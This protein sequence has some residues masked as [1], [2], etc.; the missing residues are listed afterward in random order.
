[1]A[2]NSD[3]VQY[4]ADPCAG[5]GEETEKKMFGSVIDEYLELFNAKCI[6]E[7]PDIALI[8]LLSSFCAPYYGGALKI[9]EESDDDERKVLIAD[10]KKCLKKE[11][12]MSFYLLSNEGVKNAANDDYFDFCSR[13]SVWYEITS[14]S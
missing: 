12:T 8:D 14:N 2:G 7:L 3:F 10:V 13:H 11:A 6:D 9:Y 4:I 5:A 1:M